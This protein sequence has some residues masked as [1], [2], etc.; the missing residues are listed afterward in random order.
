MPVCSRCGAL[1]SYTETHV[2]E[3]RDK[4][5]LAL[6]TAVVVGAVIGGSV[7]LLY[8]KCDIAQACARPDATNLCGLTTGPV[9]PFSIA[10]GAIIGASVATF[11]VVL[12]LR[13][14]KA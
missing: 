14:R 10:I 12:I 9:I 7:G 3:G 6:L 8:A 13:R 11:A 1:F 5:I 4:T 2:C